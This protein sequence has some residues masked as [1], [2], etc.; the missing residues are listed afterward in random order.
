MGRGHIWKEIL[1]HRE[2][3]VTRGKVQ[4][5]LGANETNLGPGE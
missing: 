5:K 2:R 1:G 3:L 4:G